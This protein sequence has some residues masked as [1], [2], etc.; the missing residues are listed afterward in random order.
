MSSD[1]AQIVD[2]SAVVAS[3]VPGV[4]AVFGLGGGFYDDPLRPGQGLQPV[5]EKVAMPGTHTSDVPDAPEIAPMTQTGTFE[6]VW[7][8]PMRLYVARS[9]LIDVRRA[10]VPFYDAYLA[11]FARDRTLAGLCSLSHIKSMSVEA[12][13]AWAWL[14]MD[15]SVQEFV[16]W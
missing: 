7:S 16:A 11:A 10:L 6:L 1:I 13:D 15:L 14:A 12:D 9:R 5:P 8:V 3:R 4:T 2:Y